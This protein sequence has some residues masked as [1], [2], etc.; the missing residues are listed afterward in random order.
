ME[1]LNPK[2]DRRGRIW[3]VFGIGQEWMQF[4]YGTHSIIY[5][6][7]VETIIIIRPESCDTLQDW[8]HASEL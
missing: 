8:L 1:E 4:F 5:D 6:S 7:D 2:I 3:K